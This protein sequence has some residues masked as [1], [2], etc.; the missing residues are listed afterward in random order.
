M[1]NFPNPTDAARSHSVNSG[2]LLAA[3]QQIQESFQASADPRDLHADWLAKILALASC[4]CGYCAEVQ[5]DS[6]GQP[7]LRVFAI[8]SLACSPDPRGLPVLVDA[9]GREFGDL[10]ELFDSVMRTGAAVIANTPGAELFGAEHPL[11]GIQVKSFLALPIQRAGVVLGILGIANR[12]GGFDPRLATSLQP[13]LTTCASLIEAQ[14][15]ARVRTAQHRATLQLAHERGVLERLA[16]MDPLETVL[17]ALILGHE[18]L[19]PGTLGSVL[20]LHAD[21]RRLVHGAS[22]S[23]PEAYVHA[24]DGVEIGP[25]VGSCGTAAFLRE[26]VIVTDIETDPRWARYKDFALRFSLRACWSVPIL[27]SQGEVLG[28]FAFY[29]HEPRAP[30]QHELAAIESSV[31]IA[32]LAIER[33]RGEAEL[34]MFAE[35][36]ALATKSAQ[37]GIFDYDILSGR[38]DWDDQMLA[39]YGVSRADFKGTYESW[40]DRVHPDDLKVAEEGVNGSIESQHPFEAAFRVIRP[41]GKVRFI[42]AATTMQRDASGRATRM[43]GVNIDVTTKNELE[44]Q[45]LRSQRLQSVGRLAGGLAHDLNNL[46]APMLIGPAMLR[47]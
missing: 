37:M 29:Y 2:Q 42:E 4:D 13:L 26:A 32:R 6:H 31:R 28:T 11:A 27:T 12:P 38:L 17:E 21:G 25:D 36:L 45:L 3:I 44:S 9:G 5:F 22:P 46:L 8:S 39:I 24:L 33:K 30:G 41:D 7:S 47:P 1:T 35:R 43:T 20:L 15:A 16:R 10:G 18:A 14:R 23:L 34:R 19:F 40:R